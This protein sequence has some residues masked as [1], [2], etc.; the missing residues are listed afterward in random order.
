[1]KLHFLLLSETGQ[2]FHNFCKI[3]D[4]SPVVGSKAIKGSHIP[5]TFLDGEVLN[6]FQLICLS[7]HSFHIDEVSQKRNLGLERQHFEGFSFI[8]AS[9]GLSG[10]L[11]N[12][13]KSS[14]SV[15]AKMIMSSR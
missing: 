9:L 10:T 7:F 4:K 15:A 2:W 6:N 13:A 3:L 14:F 1:L 5:Y 11:Q 8:P 12:L